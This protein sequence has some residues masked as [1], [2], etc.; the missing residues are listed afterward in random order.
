M[1]ITVPLNRI[2]P[3][4]LSSTSLPNVEVSL[5]GLTVHRNRASA[6][7][8]PG[9]GLNGAGTTR[10]GVGIEKGVRSRD[11]SEKEGRESREELE[12][13]DGGTGEKGSV[14]LTDMS[15]DIWMGKIQ[16][17][18]PGQVFTVVFDTGSSVS[19][20][21]ERMG[22]GRRRT[23]RAK[24]TLLFGLVSVVVAGSLGTRFEL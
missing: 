5:N 12:R 22:K 13:R 1:G 4:D 2:I 17:G 14:K 21:R 16:I 23:R 9:N 19:F 8:T 7:Y 3:L 6:K 11:V 10:R 15:E 20:W 24:L 18:T